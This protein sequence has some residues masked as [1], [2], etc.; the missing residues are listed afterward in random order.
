MF[1]E[2]QLLA[3]I[4]LDLIVGDPKWFPHPV[5]IIG[6]I[7][8]I[9]EH[10]FR[11]I[12]PSESIAG[13]V[14]VISVL[15]ISTAGTAFSLAVL[16]QISPFIAL[17]FAIF[18]LYTTVAIRDLLKHSKAVY[19]HL[20]AADVSGLAPARNAVGMIVGR[21]TSAL[22]KNGIIRATIETVAENMVDGITAP[23]FYAIL[24]TLLAPVTGINPLYLAVCGAIA[25]KAVN[26][27]DS[28]I[29]YKNTRYLVFG[30]WAAHLDDYINYIPAR[31]SGILLIPAA[32]FCGYDSK[33]AL[34]VFT[35]DR[36]AHTSPNAAHTEAAVAGALGLVLGGTL[37]Y[38][39]REIVKP[40][41]GE[42]QQ[43]ITIEDILRTHKLVLSGSFLFL[44]FMLLLRILL[45]LIIQ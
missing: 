40:E 23:L 15:F 35:K 20:A 5:R 33:S 22:D 27:M 1:F 34:R 17:A 13:L 25:Y 9:F 30:K 4:G 24:S 37:T 43:E 7:C 8:N 18:L 21:D 3:A 6:S 12:C 29:A 26:T 28:M 39:D 36:L 41:I 38:F 31:V 42:N 14:T 45:L 16:H 44:V 2:I 19:I 10:A 11:M 32:A